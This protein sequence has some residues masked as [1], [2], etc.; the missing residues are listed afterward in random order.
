MNIRMMSVCIAVTVFSATGG[1]AVAA[2][3]GCKGLV[4]DNCS[5]ESSCRWVNPYKRTDGRE[6]TGYCRTLP[7]KPA[8]QK[9]SKLE[10]KG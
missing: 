6:V 5:K 7:G 1:V 8:Q 9:I 10:D 2:E 4:E 3:A